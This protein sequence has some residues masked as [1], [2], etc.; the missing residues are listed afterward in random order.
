MR[1]LDAVHPT[2]AEHT[3]GQ[4]WPE[5]CPQTRSLSLPWSPAEAF[6]GNSNPYTHYYLDILAKE[7][8]VE[9]E[10]VGGDIEPTMEK[11]VSLEGT[12]TH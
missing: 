10:P 6:L 5:A 1:N 12:G 9:T 3:E 8:G 4:Q 11:E 2:C 7:A